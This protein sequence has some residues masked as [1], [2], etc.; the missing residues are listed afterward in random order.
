MGY[1]VLVPISILGLEVIGSPLTLFIHHHK[2]D[3]SET[4]FGFADATT[5]TLFR[6]LLKVDGV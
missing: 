4:L 6:K 3:V 5:R 1:D 2:T